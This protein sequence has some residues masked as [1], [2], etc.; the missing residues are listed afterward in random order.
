MHAS[1][2][3]FVTPAP[4]LALGETTASPAEHLAVGA[5]HAQALQLLVSVTLVSMTVFTLYGPAGQA[6]FPDA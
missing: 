4:Q 3:A 1:G 5:S 2:T 6:M